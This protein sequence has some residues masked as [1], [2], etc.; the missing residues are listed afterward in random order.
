MSLNDSMQIVETT[1]E[2]LKLKSGQIGDVVKKK[3]E[4]VTEKNPC[5]IGFKTINNIMSGTHPSKNLVKSPSDIMCFKYAQLH[6]L[7][8]NDHLAVLKIFQDLIGFL[9][10]NTI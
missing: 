1:R 10:F 2:K 3:K 6:Q 9:T 7:K 4:V 8:W 5:Y